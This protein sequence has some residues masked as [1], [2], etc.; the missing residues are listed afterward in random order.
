[1]LFTQFEFLFV[2]LPLTL[3]TY[4]LLA[5]CVDH[6]GPAIVWLSIASLVFYAQWDVD[7]VPVI[8]VSIACNYLFGG[9]IARA[10]AR[11]NARILLFA[12]AIAANVA[13]LAY[14][15]YA[16]FGINTLNAIAGTN[17][18]GLQVAL[19]L[20]I[21]FF[22][23]TQIAYLADVYRG[24]PSEGDPAKYLLFV[25]YFPHL[26]AGPIL[27]HKEMIPQFAAMHR[28]ISARNW[29]LGTTIFAI[30]LVKKM[31]L[32]DTFA[33]FANP[34][35]DAAVRG[36]VSQFDAWIG[37]LGYSLQIYFDFSG[38][39]DM[40]IGLSLLFGIK[41]PFNFDAPYKSHSIVEFWRRWHITLSRFFRDYLY[42]PL[43]GNRRGP[44]R[45]HLNLMITML[46][47]ACGTGRG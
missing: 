24:Y 10:P 43:G 11:S 34:V 1:M 25:A 40:A 37:A 32:A 14:Y 36:P 28:A 21:S 38:Y 33:F 22:T 26:I 15:K 45:R 46:L 2:F 27:H 7:F 35:F 20:G 12:P 42:I 17:F 4:L 9:L 8:V 44:R 30:G 39:S 6:A 19:P 29:A 23:F 47:A 18:H 3:L 13:A 16:N 31:V 5:R 41:L